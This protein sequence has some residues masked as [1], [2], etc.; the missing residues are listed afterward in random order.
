MIR[1]P[2]LETN[3]IEDPVIAMYDLGLLRSRLTARVSGAFLLGAVSL[4][5]PACGDDASSAGFGEQ[6]GGGLNPGVGQGGAQDF[7]QFR[8]ILLAGDIPG[9]ETIDD[10]G[11]FNEHRIEL[12]A[13]NCGEDVCIHGQLGVM[14][15]MISGS[16]CTL[17][18]IG[19]N[20][21]ID[22][23]ELER[24]PLNLA[25][26]VDTSGS[27][28]GE[29]I[30]SVRQGL[31][32]MLDALEPEDRISLVTFDDTAR[33]RVSHVSGD[34]PEL[35]QAI[36]NLQAS[37]STNIYDGLRTAYE[38]V[39]A[40]AEA[41]LQNRVIMLS[42]GKATVGIDNDARMIDLATEYGNVG[43]GLSTIGMGGDFD[44][45]LMRGLAEE[46]AGAFYFLESPM[47][48]EEVFVEE[49]SAFLVPLAEEVQID[50]DITDGWD[51]RRIYGTKQ[52]EVY[53]N[54]GSIDIPTL[55]I[56]HRLD[57][58]D[59]EQGRRGGG[60]AIVA[61]LTPTGIETDGEVGHLSFSYRRPG[62]DELVSQEVSI[63]SPLGPWELPA[64]G[65]FDGGAVEKSFVMLNIYVGFQMAATRAE[66]G[67]D[68]TALGVLEALRGSV[69]A[70]LVE[71]PDADIE[72][73]LLYIQLF[74]DNLQERAQGALMPNPVPPEPWPAD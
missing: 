13:A 29:N 66:S 11:F 21:P 3:P 51:L 35:L 70:W 67:D 27:M 74:I 43:Y 12:P 23:A 19:M 68:T 42:D 62:S 14:G 24:P 17:V 71:N 15:N 6:G 32:R 28:Q 5:L 59:Q 63:T 41:G 8:E 46:G 31:L 18:L 1:S 40:Y 2:T 30:H 4:T 22:P 16:N 7:G 37:G 33:I 57:D 56:A 55:Q 73:D 49:V 64:N 52:A 45:E 48:V 53:G 10:V 54:Q 58:E 20:T 69:E 26:A 39:G 36:Q 38:E 61:E 44:V 34:S 60:G 9:P 72:D 25:I 65:H 50:L 47:A